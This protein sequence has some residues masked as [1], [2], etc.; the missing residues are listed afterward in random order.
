[1]YQAE[2]RIEKNVQSLARNLL[3]PIGYA[4][5]DALFAFFFYTGITTALYKQMKD[6]NSA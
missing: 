1:M 3:L 2:G 6:V 5:C 4:R